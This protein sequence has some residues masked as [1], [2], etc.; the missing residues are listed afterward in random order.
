MC[1]QG[2]FLSDENWAEKLS[3]GGFVFCHTHAMF[4]ETSTQHLW[5]SLLERNPKHLLSERSGTT[6]LGASG[7]ASFR[8]RVTYPGVTGGVGKVGAT[9]A[10]VLQ[11]QGGTHPG[12]WGQCVPKQLRQLGLWPG[13]DQGAHLPSMCKEEQQDLG[14]PQDQCYCELS[15]I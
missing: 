14:L 6:S 13:V 12:C 10:A 3:D 11:A 8:K 9:T 7:L 15:Q 2:I 5:D 1:F 4:S